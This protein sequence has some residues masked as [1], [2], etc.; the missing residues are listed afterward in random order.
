MGAYALKKERAGPPTP[1]WPGSSRPPRRAQNRGIVPLLVPGT[2]PGMTH[3]MRPGMTCFSGRC[4]TD[5][6][7]TADRHVEAFL[8]ML[9]AERG[10]ARN[11]RLAY[12]LDLTDFATFTERRGVAVAKADAAT[13]QACLTA[14]EGGAQVVRVHDVAGMKSALQV[15]RRN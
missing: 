11:T 4:L 9:A 2:S 14:I 13:V 12:E 15:F 10:S 1:S 3:I 8:E 5:M 6:P 7:A